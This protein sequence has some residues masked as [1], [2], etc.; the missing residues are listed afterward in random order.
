MIVKK[1]ASSLRTKILVGVFALI[2]L[3]GGYYVYVSYLAPPSE[4]DEPVVVNV[5]KTAQERSYVYN[6]NNDIFTDSQYL[7]LTKHGVVEYNNQYKGMVLD[8]NVPLAP[9]NVDVM[10]PRTGGVLV[11]QWQMPEVVNYNGTIIY[12]SEVSGYSGELIAQ[13]TGNKTSYQDSELDN[14]KTYY[15][16][17]K[18]YKI[19]DDIVVESENVNQITGRPTDMFPPESPTKIKVEESEDGNALMISWIN[20]TDEDFD[21]IRIYRSTQKGVV[22]EVPLYDEVEEKTKIADNGTVKSYLV[23]NYR[24]QTNVN[25]YYTLTSVDTSGNE[26]GKDILTIPLKL[27]PFEPF[28]L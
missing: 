4:E 19:I 28:A 9:I 11:I 20:P 14:G 7:G 1:K 18:T 26:S 12:R 8:E 3:G 5:L 2:M 22:G 15:Y 25:Y 6:F 27:N 17:I 23:D 24:V 21:Y 16:L 13:I 10:N